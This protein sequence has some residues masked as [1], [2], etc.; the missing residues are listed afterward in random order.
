MTITI[1]QL[2]FDHATYDA[3]G[4]VLYMHVGEPQEA[5]DADETPEGHVVRYGADGQVIGLTILNAKWLMD[6]HEPIT[7]TIPERVA[8]DPAILALAITAA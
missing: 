1:G 3:T 2:S 5:T 8:F 6:R 7:V 4:D